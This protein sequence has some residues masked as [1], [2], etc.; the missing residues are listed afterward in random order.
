M[1]V[2]SRIRGL[3]FPPKCAACGEL[4]DWYEAPKR[5]DALCASCNKKWHSEKLETCGHCAKRVTECS[6]MPEDLRKSR[7]LGLRKLTYYLHGTREPV[8]NLLIYH[9][10]ENRDLTATAFLASELLPTLEELLKANGVAPQDAILT[11]VPRGRAAKAKYGT[12]QAE[13]L[14]RMLS[15]KSDIPCR[16]LLDRTRRS[17]REQ[18]RLTADERRRNVRVAFCA[19]RDEEIDQKLLFLVDDIVTTGTS[20]AACVRILREMGAKKIYCISVAS[21]D[22][23][24]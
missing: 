22:A 6:C 19:R 9:I 23:N 11:Y 3:L 17:S 1:N 2:F 8:Q 4:L 21:D 24:R 13:L 20:A 18:K 7:C 15:R 14:A 12:D 5:E 16:R 10:K